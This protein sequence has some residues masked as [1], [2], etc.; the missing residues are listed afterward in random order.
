MPEYTLAT[1]VA[2]FAVIAIEVAWARTGIFSTAQFWISMAIV[3]AFQ[4]LVDGRL[5]RLPNAIVRY[6]PNEFSGVRFPLDIPIEDFGFGFTLVA[7]TIMLWAR[8]GRREVRG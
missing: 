8:L 3:W 4:V 5:T 7:A 2:V 1:I 6:A